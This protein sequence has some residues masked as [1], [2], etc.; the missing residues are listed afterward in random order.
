LTEAIMTEDEWLTSVDPEAMLGCLGQIG[1]RP[2]RVSERRL[3]LIAAACARHAWR[4]LS[5]ERS[6]A[7]VAA[8]E[9]EGVTKHE[10]AVEKAGADSAQ[11]DVW[12]SVRDPSW[13]PAW[14]A[15]LWA[16]AAVDDDPWDWLINGGSTMA[17]TVPP[18]AFAGIVRD[19]IRHPT[20][21]RRK[22]VPMT[23]DVR[24]LA[25]A[26]CE[27]RQ[28]PAGHLVAARLAVLSDALEEAGCSDAQLLDHLRSAGPHVR[29]CWAVDAVLGRE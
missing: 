28:L 26:A 20:K 21:G 5:D 27:E 11:Y 18:E 15:A 25:E 10:L 17:L 2:G 6:R 3:R 9:R 14:S 1:R 7:A 13:T 8:A 4:H 29:G 19:V 16:K 22:P 24:T 12:N 23:A